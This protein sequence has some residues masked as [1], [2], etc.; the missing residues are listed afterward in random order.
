V[1][2]S[3][4]FAFTARFG[5]AL[6]LVVRRMDMAVR[7]VCMM[8][9]MAVDLATVMCVQQVMYVGYGF[10]CHRYFPLFHLAAFLAKL[11]CFFVLALALLPGFKT[12][13]AS[14]WTL[15]PAAFALAVNSPLCA[16]LI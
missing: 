9:R 15:F 11:A 12:A 14:S 8:G 2:L 6:M 4:D 7:M 5:L 1:M 13:E 16:G 10:C 3:M